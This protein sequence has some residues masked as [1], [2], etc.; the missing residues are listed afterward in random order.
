VRIA[1]RAEEDK[2]DHEFRIR[3]CTGSIDPCRDEEE[4]QLL[5]S[6]RLGTR[7]CEGKSELLPRST[8][9]F[10]VSYSLV[11]VKDSNSKGLSFQL[12]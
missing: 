6:S 8:E 1:G 4:K 7:I 3:G 10:L 9:Q 2:I 11:H 12:A 5:S